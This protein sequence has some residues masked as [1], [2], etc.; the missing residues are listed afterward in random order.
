NIQALYQA[1]AHTIVDDVGYLNSPLFSVG[2][3]GAAADQVASQGGLY[4]TAAGNDGNHGYRTDSSPLDTTGGD[5]PRTVQNLN[6]AALQTFT[7]DTGKSAEL[8]FRWSEAY[9]EGGTPDPNFQ[10]KA[11]YAVYVVNPQ[12]N[13][14]VATF[15]DDNANTDQAYEQVNFTND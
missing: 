1:G 6:G 13:Q 12:T 11:D 5:V 9:L 2:R 8:G 15:D 10:V 3:I 7:L 4:I 14:V